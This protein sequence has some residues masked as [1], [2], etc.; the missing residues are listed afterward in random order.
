M[1]RERDLHSRCPD[2]LYFAYIPVAKITHIIT[3]Y[4]GRSQII[5]WLVRVDMLTLTAE[6]NITNSGD[7]KLSSVT[8]LCY[9]NTVS[10]TAM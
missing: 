9:L 3:I 1:V 4:L 6:G 7:N 8:D 10:E 2:A 5:G